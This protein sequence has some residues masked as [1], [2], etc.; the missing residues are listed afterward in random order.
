[1]FKFLR[2]IKEEKQYLIYLYIH[3][4]LTF[5]LFYYLWTVI[6]FNN[7]ILW[8]LW[9]A[10]LVFHLIIHLV[11]KKWKSNVF[12]NVHS[13]I[14]IVGAGISGLISLFLYHFY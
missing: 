6:N 5:F 4:P 10:F 9:N 3:I 8:V 11:A 12:R 14:F 2:K 1:M 13:F 7:I